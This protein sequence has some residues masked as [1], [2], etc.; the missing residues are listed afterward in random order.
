MKQYQDLIKHVLSNGTDRADRTGTGIKSVFG[1]Q[2]RFDLQQ[3]FP[4]LT[5][6]KKSIGTLSHTNYSGSSLALPPQST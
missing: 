2:M 6:K 4:I 1:Y 3:G 5:T